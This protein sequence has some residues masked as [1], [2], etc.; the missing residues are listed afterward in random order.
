[1]VKKTAADIDH[2]INDVLRKDLENLEKELAKNNEELIEF[3][4]LEKSLEFL[5]ENKP[6]GF[7]TKVDVGSNMFI[8]ANVPKIE[9][10]LINIGLNTY[11]ELE[12]EE[13]LKFLKM[14]SNI[15]NKESDVIRE[16]TLKIRSEI[17][18]LLMYL[19]EQDEKGM[20]LR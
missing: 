18:I 5:K 7:T 10:I 20:K 17:K 3:M 14:K 11:L 6:N 13:A 9:P 1:M 8:Q 2:V 19:A 4:Q 16:Q 12:L 15:L